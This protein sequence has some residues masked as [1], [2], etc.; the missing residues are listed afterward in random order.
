MDPWKVGWILF[1]IFS[2]SGMGGKTLITDVTAYR[3]T[4]A[5]W[6]QLKSCDDALEFI[7]RLLDEVI[8]DE[9]FGVSLLPIQNKCAE[10]CT[11]EDRGDC[12]FFEEFVQDMSSL[13]SDT[14]KEILEFK[15]GH[16][17]TEIN[18]AYEYHGGEDKFWKEIEDACNEVCAAVGKRDCSDLFSEFM[19]NGISFVLFASLAIFI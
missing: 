19:V 13:C 14:K 9:K 8:E 18:A 4:D 5:P 3:S 7:Q 6:T 1:F 12:E 11:A 16:N 17:Q 15:A 10:L 2:G